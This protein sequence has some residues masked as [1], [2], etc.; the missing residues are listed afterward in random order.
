M[1]HLGNSA[2]EFFCSDIDGDW[3]YAQSQMIMIFK[4]FSSTNF[5]SELQNLLAS[6]AINYSA[7][8]NAHGYEF[9]QGNGFKIEHPKFGGVDVIIIT[10]EDMLPKAA[11][12]VRSTDLVESVEMVKWVDGFEAIYNGEIALSKY[13][14]FSKF[15]NVPLLFF[16]KK[17]SLHYISIYV[18]TETV[19]KFLISEIVNNNNDKNNFQD[20]EIEN[21][22][23]LK[24]GEKI[25][26]GYLP[27]EGTVRV[28]K[29]IEIKDEGSRFFN[30]DLIEI[31]DFERE[32]DEYQNQF[33]DDS[34]NDIFYWYQVIK[35]RSNSVLDSFQ[36]DRSVDQEISELI[37][38]HSDEYSNRMLDE[39]LESKIEF[40]QPRIRC[41]GVLF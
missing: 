26:V 31:L 38:G 12:E 29:N 21:W 16:N 41:F 9:W 24:K 22:K 5:K 40:I 23:Y 1:K 17:D 10:N 15:I 28:I 19:A 34:L 39:S 2:E 30:Q 7:V 14:D 11:A 8:Q 37:W 18:T 25:Y 6:N 3:Y 33:G 4:S 32:L 20:H 27:A 35:N 36:K 13:K